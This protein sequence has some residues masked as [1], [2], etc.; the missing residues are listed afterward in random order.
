MTLLSENFLRDD[1]HPD[2][3]VLTGLNIVLKDELITPE[4]DLIVR[5]DTVTI[6]G[7]LSLPG[8]LVHIFARQVECAEDAAI[9]VSGLAGMPDYTGMAKP[10]GAQ[11]PG[12]PGADGDNG[13]DGQNGGEIKIVAQELNGNIHLFAK[14]GQGGK[15]QDG[16]DGV[17]GRRGPDG[18]KEVSESEKS[19]AHAENGKPG[20]MA[21]TAGIPGKGG[22]GGGIIVAIFNGVSDGQITADY[23]PG[24]P[25]AK[26]ENGAPGAG[27]DPGS[28]GS[29]LVWREGHNPIH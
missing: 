2:R 11:E 6:P 5:A 24:L 21:G 29:Y 20:G 13:G 18:K 27:G 23:S 3:I 26:A 10:M 19:K 7:K 28:R 16:G 9:D 12:S 4:R 25:G 8:R 14:G 22:N 17:K 1:T 15:A